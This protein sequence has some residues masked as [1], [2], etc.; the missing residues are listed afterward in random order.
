MYCCRK[1]AILG[2]D[3]CVLIAQDSTTVP[4]FYSVLHIFN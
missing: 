3:A 4:G 2:E 1:R